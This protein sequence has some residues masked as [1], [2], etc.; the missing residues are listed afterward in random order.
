[1]QYLT[2]AQARERRAAIDASSDSIASSCDPFDSR[3]TGSG[4][5][6]CEQRQSLPTAGTNHMISR[7]IH[8]PENSGNISSPSDPRTSRLPLFWSS[9]SSPP[10]DELYAACPANTEIGLLPR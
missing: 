6:T 4:G 9:S 5:S 10:T 8:K 2:G 1:M 7:G 3:L